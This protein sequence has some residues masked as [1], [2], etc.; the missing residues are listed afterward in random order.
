MGACSSTDNAVHPLKPIIVE[1]YPINNFATLPLTS[2]LYNFPNDFI[3]R[4][5]D[6]QLTSITRLELCIPNPDDMHY[7]ELLE[8]LEYCEI[9]L[10]NTI[11]FRYT[12]YDLQLISSIQPN[13]I[14]YNDSCEKEVYVTLIEF[15]A[16][17]IKNIPYADFNIKCKW[18]PSMYKIC[19]GIEARLMIHGH[20]GIS[21]YDKFTD[22][23]PKS[24]KALYNLKLFIPTV[25]LTAQNQLKSCEQKNKYVIEIKEN[26]IGI[27]IHDDGFTDF[28]N[29]LNFVV[30]CSNKLNT[31]AQINKY[32][33]NNKSN[34]R[35]YYLIQINESVVQKSLF[36]PK[37]I[38]RIDYYN[39]R[40]FIEIF[41]KND[42][43]I[44]Y[45]EILI[46]ELNVF[47]GG[48]NII[49]NS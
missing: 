48:C 3:L 26:C 11:H 44:W 8:Q 17:P 24:Q 15:M 41:A 29:E 23:N 12:G 46:T 19:N 45:K 21:P 7:N 4:L 18:K 34:I 20:C 35:T 22:D 36:T 27:I 5:N 40:G 14:N 38:Y 16:F 9:M 42:L 30:K 13:I 39:H 1:G 28:L 49:K 47:A 37:I 33:I 10:G 2:K 31:Y 43:K 32:I 6:I 25:L